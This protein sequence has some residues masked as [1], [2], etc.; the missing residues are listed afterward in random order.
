MCQQPLTIRNPKFSTHA[1]NHKQFNTVPCGKCDICKKSR[2][3]SWIFR[4]KKELEISS[5]P[6]FLTLTY[7][8]ENIKYGY[9]GSPTL[10]KRDLQL[11]YKRLRFNLSKLGISKPIKYYSVGEYGKKFGRPHYHAILLNCDNISIISESWNLGFV[12]VS[13]LTE[14]R[15][16]YTLKYISKSPTI[17]KPDQLKE[18]SLMSKKIGSNYLTLAIKNYHREEVTLRSYITTKEGFKMP[19]PKYYKNHLFDDEMLQQLTSFLQHRAEYYMEDMAYKI[20]RQ[21]SKPYNIVLKNL[22][23]SKLNFKLCKTSD[24]VL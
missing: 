1:G 21:T 7:N 11:F 16:Y 19:I 22:E 2:L 23:I 18:F 20:S 5:T 17:L 8:D 12:G 3:N 9:K 13:K 24:G 14:K 15:M 10:Y 4:L 6:L